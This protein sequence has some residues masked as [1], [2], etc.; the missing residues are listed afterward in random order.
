MRY[1]VLAG[2]GTRDTATTV[3]GHK[4]TMPVLVAPSAFHGLAHPLGERATAQGAAAAGVIFVMSTLSNTRMEDVAKVSTGPRWFQLYVNKDRGVTRSL[5]QRAEAAGF[6]ALELTVD[7]PV[8]GQRGER[9][10][11]PFHRAHRAGHR[12]GV[13]HGL[14]AWKSASLSKTAPPT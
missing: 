8:L 6:T 9:W 1:G 7:A 13:D 14:D 12:P 4:M 2:V 5:V 3:L 10:L 11:E